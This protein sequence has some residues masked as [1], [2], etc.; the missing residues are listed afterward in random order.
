MLQSE[1]YLYHYHFSIENEIKRLFIVVLLKM[2][3]DVQKTIAL[4]LVVII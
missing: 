1:K 2:E 3:S 4:C